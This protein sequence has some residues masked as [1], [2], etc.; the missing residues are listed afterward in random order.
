MSRAGEGPELVVV[1]DGGTELSREE[2]GGK[3]WSIN[4]MR[5]LGLPVPPAIVATTVNCRTFREAGGRIPD[6]LWQAITAR[7]SALEQGTGRRFGS[8]DRPLLVSV[9]SGAARSMPGMMDT[10]L[11]LGINAEI[12]A[13]LAAETGDPAYAADTR[14]RFVEAYRDVVLGTTGG[15]VPAAPWDQLRGAVEAV[16]ASWDSPRAR[17]YR[18]SRGVSDDGGT[19]VTIQAMVFGNLGDRSGTGVVFS[20]DPRTGENRPF[21]EWLP[22]GQGED[23]VSGRLDPQ[24][25]ESLRE[26]LPAVYAELTAVA[27]RIER[28]AGD[29]QDIEFT[30]EGGRLWLLQSRTAKRSPRAAVRAAVAMV[31]EGILDPGSA[32]RR[33]TAEQARALLAPSLDRS[34]LT[35]VDP[36]ATGHPVCEGVATGTVVVDPDEAERRA[37]AGEDVVLARATTSPDDMHGLV[38]ARAVITEHGGSTSHAAVVSRELGRVCVVGCGSGTVTALA[39]NRVTVDGASGEIWPGAAALIRVSKTTTRI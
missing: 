38:A 8:P 34:R 18:R 21:G 36:V 16:F 12:E 35:G 3:A 11:D 17:A 6:D 22:G 23:V 37:E 24:P 28:D 33:V 32:L 10:V 27:S 31:D 30:V 7:M 19:A 4:R 26:Q 29:I 25:L 5:A 14:R 20:R 39:G 2:L 1:L 9:R 15:D 13:G